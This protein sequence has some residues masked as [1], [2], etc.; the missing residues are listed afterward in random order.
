MLPHTINAI[1]L[2]CF[3]RHAAA[4]PVIGHIAG[5]VLPAAPQ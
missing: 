1:N 5:T 4:G 2:A 3:G